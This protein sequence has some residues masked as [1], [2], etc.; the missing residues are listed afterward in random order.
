MGERI[1]SRADR[2]PPHP[3]TVHGL[4]RTGAH[5]MS[6]HSKWATIR[7]HKKG[8]ADKKRGKLFA[9][10]IRQVEVA[11]REGGGDPAQA[12]AAHDVPEG[13]GRSVPLDTIERAIKRGTGELEGVQYEQGSYEATPRAA[14]RVRRGAD[15]QQ[16]PCRLGDPAHLHHP[17]WLAGRTGSGRLAV[18]PQGR[19]GRRPIGGGGRPDDGGPRR[20][21]RGHRRRGRHLASPASRATSARCGRRSKARASPSSRSTSP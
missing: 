8:A 16:E 5:R 19:A 18:R 9:K 12:H 17:R 14:C 21:A 3:P 4:D 1:P 11:A 10:L 13:A 15:R 7:E 6:G 2:R 20:R